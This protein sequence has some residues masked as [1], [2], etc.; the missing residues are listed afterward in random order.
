MVKETLVERDISDGKR[1]IRI[2]DEQGFKVSSAFWLYSSKREEWNLFL[3]SEY[4]DKYG[5]EKSYKFIK[6]NLLKA[7]PPI[8]IA[9]SDINVVGE[10]D[11]LV[12]MLGI[13][14]RTGPDDLSEIRFTENVINGV[15][16]EEAII[17]RLYI[18]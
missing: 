12:K 9:L 6:E 14:I 16:I 7:D 4:V 17:Y 5:T 10:K 8:M 13:L 11:N 18:K 2:L 1:L 15:L 3:Y